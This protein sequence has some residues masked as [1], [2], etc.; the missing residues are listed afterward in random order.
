MT[1]EGKGQQAGGRIR[2]RELLEQAE[3][4]Y[5]QVELVAGEGGL[6]REITLARIQKPGLALT[7]YVDFVKSGRVQ[8]L[9][10]SEIGYL[11]M[12]D[13]GERR[14]VLERLCARPIPCLAVTKAQEVP[15]ELLDLCQQRQIP[16]LVSR[17]VSSVFIDRI[18]IFLDS[19]L[20][21]RTTVH[22]V[23]MDI[24]GIGVLII[25]RSGVG[26]SELALDLVVRGH[27]LVTD[28]VVEIRRR[29]GDILVGRGPELIRHHMELRGIGIINIEHMFGAASFRTRK[30]VEMVVRLEEW[31]DGKEYDRLGLEEQQH[32]VLGLKLPLVRLPVASG[33][34]LSILIEVAVRNMILKLSGYHP[35]EDL[36]QRLQ[37]AMENPEFVTGTF[38]L[39]EGDLE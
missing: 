7:G 36:I 21:P 38:D 12:I 34:N 26:K 16:L 4:E 25:G 5:L 9:G 6:D 30:R 22:G 3:P 27:R 37:E 1:T 18:T 15:P 28:D 8:V 31:N 24:Y 19:Q 2:V 33:R 10:A 17:L 35:A 14:S 32:D 39:D 29:Q 20:A 13:S 23:L 11:K